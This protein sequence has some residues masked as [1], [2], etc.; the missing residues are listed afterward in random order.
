MPTYKINGENPWTAL[1]FGA[2]KLTPE[3]FDYCV[4]EDPWTAIKYCADKLT[5][6]QKKYC[7]V[8]KQN[9]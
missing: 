7:E 2:D 5:N 6:E 3:E 4:H 8:K 9:D 1:R